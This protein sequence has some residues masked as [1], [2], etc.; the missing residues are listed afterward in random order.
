[1]LHERRF[2]EISTTDICNEAE[3]STSS[4]YARFQSKD[5]ILL[6][7]IERHGERLLESIEFVGEQLAEQDPIDLPELV[8]ALVAEAVYFA[9][10]YDHLEVAARAHPDARVRLQEVNE[11]PTVWILERTGQLLPDA[12]PS[13]RRRLEFGVRA[14]ASVAHRAVG[15]NVRF[16]DHMDMGDDELIDEISRLTLAYVDAALALE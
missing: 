13:L 14:A 7:L 3:V 6:A 5:A 16:V 8:R 4:L 11:R 15:G 12:S 2:D 1:M 10:A 9:H